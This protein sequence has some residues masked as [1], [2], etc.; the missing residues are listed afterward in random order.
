[1]YEGSNMELKK[2]HA[3]LAVVVFPLF[4]TLIN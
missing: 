4:P 3:G 2:K 1:M